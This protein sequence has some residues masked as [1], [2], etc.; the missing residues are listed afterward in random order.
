MLHHDVYW[1]VNLCGLARMAYRIQSARASVEFVYE[2]LLT[3]AGLFNWNGSSMGEGN[4]RRS[5]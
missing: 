1:P 2:V 3:F 5:A 4:E